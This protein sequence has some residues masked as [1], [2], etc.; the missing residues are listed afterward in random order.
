MRRKWAAQ[1]GG[2]GSFSR[3]AQ[4][5][6]WNS[7]ASAIEKV[8]ARYSRPASRPSITAEAV[9]Y[10]LPPAGCTASWSAGLG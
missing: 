10:D 9:G 8:P 5:S 1:L 3:S 2:S 4:N 7:A 6:V